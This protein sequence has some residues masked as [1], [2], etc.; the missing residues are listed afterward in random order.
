MLVYRGGSGRV[1]INDPQAQSWNA[2]F[3]SFNRFSQR[4]GAF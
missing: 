2:Y 4:R 3:T 1:P